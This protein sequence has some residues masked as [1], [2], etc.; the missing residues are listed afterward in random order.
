MLTGRKIK[1]I[2]REERSNSPEVGSSEKPGRVRNR[3]EERK[4]DAVAIVTDWVSELHR[5]KAEEATYG[6]ERLFGNAG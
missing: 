3:L 2:K 6:F 4:R 5:K 1:I